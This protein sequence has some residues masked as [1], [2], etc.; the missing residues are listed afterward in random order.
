MF[1]LN[2]A[3][4]KSIGINDKDERKKILAFISDFSTPQKVSKI[5]TKV[6]HLRN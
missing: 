5:V 6:P 2:D 3:D 1:T 4:L